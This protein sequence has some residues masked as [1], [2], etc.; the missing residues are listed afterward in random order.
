MV[1]VGGGLIV[2]A[3]A[4]G[5][6]ALTAAAAALAF[7]VG[8]ATIVVRRPAP[9]WAWS[10][11]LLGSAMIVFAR[12]S[13]AVTGAPLVIAGFA[14]GEIRAFVF[15]SAIVV[16]LL[17]LGGRTAKRDLADTIDAA[18]VALGSFC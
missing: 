17:L 14:V 18:I 12:V 7:V 9:P 11:L 13:F 15:Y 10:I 1:V 4:T 5:S 3:A 16:G 2:G 8:V 6:R